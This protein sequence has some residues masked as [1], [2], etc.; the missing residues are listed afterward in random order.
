VA[1]AVLLCAATAAA[2]GGLGRIDFPI[3]CGDAA[4]EHFVRGVLALHSFSYELARAEF[5]GAAKAEPSCAM[6]YWG[7]A[8]SHDATLW[9]SQDTSDGRLALKKAL[10]LRPRLNEK[11]AAFVDAAA[12]LFGADGDGSVRPVRVHAYVD[13]LRR[14][15]QHWPDDDEI[16]TFFALALMSAEDSARPSLRDRMQAGALALEVLG[17]NSRHPGALHYAIHAFDDPDHA[18][19]ALPAARAYAAIAPD[20]PHAR[21]MPAHIFVELGDWAEA[22]A[23]CES[24]WHVSQAGIAAAAGQGGL[25]R[26]DVHSLGWLGS[27]YVELGQP[28][29]AMASLDTLGRI[30]GGDPRAAFAYLSSATAVMRDTDAWDRVEAFLAPAVSALPALDAEY[31]K[32]RAPDAPPIPAAMRALIDGAR[33][34]AAARRHDLDGARRF[35]TALMDE[36]ARAAR[37]APSFVD[38]AYRGEDRI[39]EL[40]VQAEIALASGQP[41][42]AEAALRQALPLEE[43]T[44]Q[45][46]GADPA[47]ASSYE[48]LGELAFA[49]G[50][51]AQAE[52]HFAHALDR[53]PGR[54]RALRGVALAAE[55][56]GDRVRASDA[57]RSLAR[58][59]SH[60]DA[61]LPGLAE[62]QSHLGPR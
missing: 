45:A 54:S 40:H 56:L 29:Q 44:A 19:L 23:A 53:V 5:Q 51:Y 27:L 3:D 30:I 35:T 28:K 17:R 15:H 57:W 32:N 52:A 36:H 33:A 48:R 21:H 18:P 61:D 12:A 55:R 13:S 26:G 20:A 16:T 4:R 34:L 50:N 60:A 8:M 62:V 46:N 10:A 14:M 2:D 43:T 24:A 59:W 9:R 49:T 38:E 11:H 41:A 22:A 25:Y 1:A 37:L 39:D 7:D 31:E 47:R 58:N 6:A 42:A